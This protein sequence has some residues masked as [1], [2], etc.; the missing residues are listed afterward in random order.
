MKNATLKKAKLLTKYGYFPSE[1][2]PLFTTQKFARILKQLLTY[3]DLDTTK[4]PIEI[5]NVKCKTTKSCVYSIAKKQSGFRRYLDIL[6]PYSFLRLALLI[7]DSY[8]GIKKN[9]LKSKIN[10]TIITLS[11]T[12]KDNYIQ[13]N[14]MDIISEHT[15]DLGIDKKYLVKTDISEFYS[16]VYT[17]I[18]SWVIEGKDVSKRNR[19][20]NALIGNRID[21]AIGKC[22]D[23]QTYGIATGPDTSLLLSELI[24]SEIDNE[25]ENSIDNLTAI[26]YMDDYSFFCDSYDMA[27]NILVIVEK[28]LKKYE[29]RINPSKTNIFK[30][31]YE[32]NPYWYYEVR[33]MFYTLEN[34]SL[35]EQNHSILLEF[36]EKLFVLQREN[37]ND[38]VARYGISLID[39]RY[40]KMEIEEN[41]KL[42]L[43]KLLLHTIK[44]EPSVIPLVFY[45]FNKI[46]R[47]NIDLNVLKKS[48]KTFIPSC[49][50]SNYINEVCWALLFY[51]Y[52][53]I[54]LTYI[55]I[56]EFIK[57]D[58]PV[59]IIML[60]DIINSTLYKDSKIPDFKAWEEL[61]KDKGSLFNENWLLA[62]ELEIQT[63]THKPKHPSYTR[64]AFFDYLIEKKVSFFNSDIN[65][66]DG[67]EKPSKVFNPYDYIPNDD[68]SD[69]YMPDDDDINHML[70]DTDYF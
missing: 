50:N 27:E 18:I 10:K 17:H 68:I 19:A 54:N 5:A 46:G 30:L 31:P 49:I 62:Y 7:S 33:K 40:E 35:R 58:N 11:L 12:S 8:K 9:I 39:T 6:N 48:L 38:G 69:D 70:N 59:A 41:E 65:I 26:R 21:W 63:W 25:L 36:F 61:I 2:P 44:V 64:N 28:I 16:S 60:L 22:Q 53:S 13:R 29:F 3:I 67:I 42:L 55:E 37:P 56:E 24:L 66:I 1:L 14:K 32:F 52:F 51:K 45:I 4:T 15:I 23:D 20:K 47:D 34:P 57:V 43:Q